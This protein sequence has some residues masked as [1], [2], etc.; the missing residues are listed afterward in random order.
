[1][2]NPHT[3]AVLGARILG[4]LLQLKARS[5]YRTPKSTVE[6]LI[7]ENICISCSR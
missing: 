6:I 5:S 4:L 7:H 2:R 3:F 1:M